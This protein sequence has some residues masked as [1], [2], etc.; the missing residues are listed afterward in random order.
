MRRVRSGRSEDVGSEGV[1]SVRSKEWG[2]KGVRG[3]G[4]RSEECGCENT[5]HC[6]IGCCTFVEQYWVNFDPT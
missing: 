2:V 5:L 4:V 1:R 3:E 6:L